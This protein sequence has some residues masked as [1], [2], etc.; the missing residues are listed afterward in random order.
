MAFDPN[1]NPEFDFPDPPNLLDPNEV[2]QGPMGNLL[3]EGEIELFF[4]QYPDL[5]NTLNMSPGGF[6][7]VG[8]A[9]YVRNIMRA[10]DGVQSPT[11]SQIIQ[12]GPYANMGDGSVNEPFLSTR[13]NKKLFPKI[14]VPKEWRMRHQS[15]RG[16]H[17]AYLGQTEAA[18]FTRKKSADAFVRSWNE[19]MSHLGSA[20][21]FDQLQLASL[22]AAVMQAGSGAQ[23]QANGFNPPMNGHGVIAQAEFI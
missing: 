20:A 18:Y 5:F 19:M 14:I 17:I 9:E 12:Q 10:S 11:P 16:G 1:A 23:G 21:Q 3:T 13:P 22:F 8:A 2:R 4:L 15:A 7:T 6:N